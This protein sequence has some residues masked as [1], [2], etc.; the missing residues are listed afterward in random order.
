MS[1]SLKIQSSLGNLI[2]TVK[3]DSANDLV[4]KA[5]LVLKKGMSQAP[6]RGYTSISFKYDKDLIKQVVQT[7]NNKLDSDLKSLD[8]ILVGSLNREIEIK[9]DELKDVTPFSVPEPEPPSL[10]NI[11]RE[12][13]ITDDGYRVPINIMNILMP[14]RKRKEQELAHQAFEK[15]HDLWKKQKGEIESEYERLKSQHEKSKIAWLQIK[16]TFLSKQKQHNLDID[17]Y[18]ELYDHPQGVVFWFSKVLDKL[19]YS[20]SYPRKNELDYEPKAKLLVVDMELPSPDDIPNV[21]AVKVNQTQETINEIPITEKERERLYDNVIYQIV[22]MCINKIYHHDIEG[23][24]DTVVLNGWVTSISKATGKETRACIL[25]IQ[26]SR[27]EFQNLDLSKVDPKSCFHSLKGIG[28]TKLHGLTPVAP[29]VSISREDKRFV[30]S[31]DVA[32]GLSEGS[33]L[34]AM[35]WEEFEQLIS[36]R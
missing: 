36:S 20:L 4:R 18:K 33:N 30:Q 11:P 24:V 21:K 25:S 6:N 8:G 7:V 13:T 28:S 35:D 9:W 3:A 17:N 10:S 32:E 29:I 16:E 19:D 22:L 31:H 34:A 27:P 26:T 12:P 2:D 23:V 14:S 15:A 1:Y 5:V